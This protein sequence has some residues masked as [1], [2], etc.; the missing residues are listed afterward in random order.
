MQAEFPEKP[1]KPAHFC[2][3]YDAANRVKFNNNL[4]SLASTNL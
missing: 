1:E 3:L 4:K 2:Q